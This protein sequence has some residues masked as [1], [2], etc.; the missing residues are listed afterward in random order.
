MVIDFNRLNPGS[1]PATTGRTGST[2][3]GRPDATGADKAGQAATSARRAASRCRSAKPPRTCRKSRTSCRPCRWSTTIRLPGSSKRSPMAP[4]RSTA[5]VLPASCSTSN[6]SADLEGRAGG[7]WTP[8]ELPSPRCLTPYPARSVRRGYRPR[9]P[10]PAVGRRRIPGPERREL[11]V[12]QQLRG[13]AA[14]DAATGAKWPGPR[15]NP[16][17]SRRFLDREGL[18]RYARERADGAEL[19]ARGD[20]L[21]E[22][23]ERCQQANLRN[24]RIIRANQASTGSL[25]NILRGQDAPSL[26]DSRGGTASSSRQRPLSQA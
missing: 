22:L 9:Q 20:E 13:Q 10:T 7:H 4:I 5:S 6:P 19:L 2:A 11:P 1:T 25:L 8:N 24:G 21:G 17:R 15:G 14:T 16:P 3:A 26:Y 23:L 12:L 18:A